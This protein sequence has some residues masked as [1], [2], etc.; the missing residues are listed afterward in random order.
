MSFIFLKT[1]IIIEVTLAFALYKSFQ[2]GQV[3]NNIKLIFQENC[4]EYVISMEVWSI[5]LQ[6]IFVLRLPVDVFPSLLTPGMTQLFFKPLNAL[7][8]SL[9]VEKQNIDADYFC[10]HQ[11]INPFPGNKFYSSKLNEFADDNFKF[12]ENGRKLSKHVKNTVGKEEIA[13]FPQCFQKTCPAD[14]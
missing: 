4:L 10:I 14:P 5:N 12:V 1:E 3:Q 13:R 9:R 11:G 6:S 8:T 7:L 2:F